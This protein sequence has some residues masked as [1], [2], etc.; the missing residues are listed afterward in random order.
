[1]VIKTKQ[2]LQILQLTRNFLMCFNINHFKN[3]YILRQDVFKIVSEPKADVT[4]AATCR[5][6]T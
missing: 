5:S 2:L 1:L 4:N 3:L 6:V